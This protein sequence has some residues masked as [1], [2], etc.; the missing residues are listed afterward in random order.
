MYA[1]AVRKS[2]H[3]GKHQMIFNGTGFVDIQNRNSNVYDL[4]SSQYD[5]AAN[6]VEALND[7][8]IY[9]ATSDYYEE[10]GLGNLKNTT[11]TRKTT[12]QGLKVAPKAKIYSIAF[13][14]TYTIVS[15]ILFLLIEFMCYILF[16]HSKE[17]EFMILFR[18][19]LG[20]II[21]ASLL[22]YIYGLCLV[23]SRDQHGRRRQQFFLW[24]PV[25]YS[26]ILCALF[27]AFDSQKIIHTVKQIFLKNSN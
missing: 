21:G 14:I 13:I 11:E 6:A 23:H 27:F 7:E 22:F 9:E 10:I 15:T 3:S 5:T 18:S 16:L 2:D 19:S 26:P 25:I 20:I 4:P 17:S 24:L 12:K 8:N 1:N